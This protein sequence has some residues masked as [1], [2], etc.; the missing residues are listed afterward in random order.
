MI[1][2]RY[3]RRNDAQCTAEAADESADLLMCTKHLGRAIELLKAKGF[4]VTA[5][6]ASWCADCKEN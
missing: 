2:C 1:Q 5:P 6:S 3:L 4:T